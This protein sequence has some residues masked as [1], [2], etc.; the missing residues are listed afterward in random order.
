MSDANPKQRSV[1][2]G[3]TAV[4]FFASIVCMVFVLLRT[5]RR[6]ETL[7][8]ETEAITAELID[9]REEAQQY[10]SLRDRER[11]DLELIEEMMRLCR[12]IEDIPDFGAR[13]VSSCRGDELFFYVP[14][15][16]HLLL[17]TTT[18][19]TNSITQALPFRG[20][21]C[22]RIPLNSKAGYKFEILRDQ[23]IKDCIGWKLESS[24]PEFGAIEQHLP[25]RARWSG[26]SWSTFENVVYP[27]QFRSQEIFGTSERDRRL[28]L[29]ETTHRGQTRNKQQIMLKFQVHFQSRSPLVASATEAASIR[30][31]GDEA[32]IGDY[33]G[34]G[35]YLV[36]E[37]AVAAYFE[38][39]ANR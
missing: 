10:E 39:K 3:I 38:R 13:F 30:Q 2:K 4:A 35:R 31:F 23:P 24:D 15:G 6:N 14:E 29:L 33:L 26:R 7:A 9:V 37:D 22:K 11:I 34:D 5:Q 17:I 28:S 20:M 27:N 8:T 25:Y 18:S 21:E 19:P 16:N 32:I 36:D 12:T 1:L